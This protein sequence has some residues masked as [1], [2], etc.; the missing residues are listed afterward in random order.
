MRKFIAVWLSCLTMAGAAQAATIDGNFDVVAGEKETYTF[1]FALLD[2][3]S[4]DSVQS[5]KVNA[6]YIAAPA[7]TLAAPG[8]GQLSFAR[9]FE[10]KDKILSVFAVL[11]IKTAGFYW[12]CVSGINGNY[13]GECT[14]YNK[15]DYKGDV[16][17]PI[18]FFAESNI[19][20][21]TAEQN[22]QRLAQTAAE[23]AVVPIAG[24][25][26]LLLSGLGLLGWFARR[27]RMAAA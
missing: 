8:V 25:L 19:R 26:P 18:E 9:S 22:A 17:A 3:E 20:V 14:G 5:F 2:G 1:N 16:I 15:V 24:T 11:N 10:L 4:F 7:F 6:D 21:M 12:Q 13:P 23:A 27:Q